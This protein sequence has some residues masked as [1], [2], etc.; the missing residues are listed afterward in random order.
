M[1]AL[2][3]V[4]VFGSGVDGPERPSCD[5]ARGPCDASAHRPRGVD[6]RVFVAPFRAP[7]RRL[8]HAV[9]VHGPLGADRVGNGAGV[10]GGEE[11]AVLEADPDD[12]LARMHPLVEVWVA[13]RD[14]SQGYGGDLVGAEPVDVGRRRGTSSPAHRSRGR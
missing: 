8:Q 2:G 13:L 5:H 3:E 9:D 6:F 7:A 14:E 4:G 10:V 1:Q 12:P 11:N